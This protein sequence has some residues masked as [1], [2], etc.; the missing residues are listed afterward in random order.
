MTDIT[1]RLRGAVAAVMAHQWSHSRNGMQALTDL[2]DAAA[3]GADEI[4]RLHAL[5]RSVMPA[6]P[7]QPHAL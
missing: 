5:L 7:K 1:D 3:A 2:V 4:D 6:D